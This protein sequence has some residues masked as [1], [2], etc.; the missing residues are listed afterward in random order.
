MTHSSAFAVVLILLCTGMLHAEDMLPVIPVPVKTDIH[1]GRFRITPGTAIVVEEATEEAG[2]YLS[3]LF[4]PLVGS[5]LEVQR[6]STENARSHCIFLQMMR[7]M[8]TFGDEG[9]ILLPSTDR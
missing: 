9:Y 6:A 7:G 1:E 8:V 2:K 5:R 4:A 3:D